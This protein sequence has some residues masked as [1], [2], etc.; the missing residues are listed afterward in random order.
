MS[1]IFADSILNEFIEHQ[2]KKAY[3]KREEILEERREFAK[4]FEDENP[5]YK[6]TIAFLF[7]LM[8]MYNE[9][10]HKIYT[11]NF[12]SNERY[13]KKHLAY[14]YTMIEYSKLKNEMLIELIEDPSC[15]KNINNESVYTGKYNLLRSFLEVAYTFKSEE[16]ENE[17][18]EYKEKN[19]K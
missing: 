12:H 8:D 4:T 10:A 7:R 5:E 1:S 15:V 16:I 2:M 14:I 13:E 11:K 17:F 6:G 19:W 9:S 3:A 18:Q